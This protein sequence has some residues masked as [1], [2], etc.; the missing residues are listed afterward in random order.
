MKKSFFS[1]LFLILLFAVSVSADDPSGASNFELAPCFGDN[2][3]FQQNEPIR[4]WGT[5]N[6]E[7]ANVN[8]ILG[9]SMA[10]A[11]VKD[12]KWELS[13]APRVYSSEPLTLE[14]YGNEDCRFQSLE[15][16][17]IGDVWFFI[18]QSNIEYTSAIAPEFEEYAAS[19]RGNE[20]IRL[21]HVPKE[22][23]VN[24]VRWRNFSRFSAYPSSA[25]GSFFA[26]FTSD[27][28]G[29]E[30]PLG[31][32]SLGY[33]GRPISD[34]MPGKSDIYQ[35]ALSVLE[36]FPVRGIVWYQGEAD[37]AQYGYYAEKLKSYIEYQRSVKELDNAEF[38]FYVM[39]LP[40]CFSGNEAGRQYIDFG[41][42][43]AETGSLPLSVNNMYI[44]PSSD[45]WDNPSYENSLHPPIKYRMA[46]RLSLMVLSKEYGFG[47]CDLFFG[48]VI[49]EYSYADNAKS[50]RI[51]FKNCGDGLVANGGLHGFTVIGKNW[52][53]INDYT[54]KIESPDSVLISA[55]EDIYIVKYAADTEDVFGKNITLSNS[56]SVPAA[57]F[58]VTLQSPPLSA[59]QKFASAYGVY[60]KIVLCMIL[61]A[62]LCFVSRLGRK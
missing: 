54:A 10:S 19:L 37:A 24:D 7:G 1:V 31:I 53:S 6:D 22:G 25:L 34:F 59:A 23:F 29:N 16:I 8:G 39:E 50:V 14:L 4:I 49:S 2:M 11:T 52:N 20:N 57:A 41:A 12:G 44:C 30:V 43:R 17:N 13:F 15:N 9:D 48:P 21:L 36:R 5:S 26:K 42:V 18:G 61:L 27:A 35:N 62:A 3:I 28:L 45:M 46:Q 32:V 47:S 55:N 40:P 33:K 56:S 51:K 38:P 58:S 60:I